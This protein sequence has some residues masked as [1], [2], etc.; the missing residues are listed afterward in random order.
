[1]YWVV[2]NGLLPMTPAGHGVRTVMERDYD[3]TALV[4]TID[5]TDSLW[6]VKRAGKA[7]W[8][9][10][11]MA[12]SNAWYR[13]IHRDFDEEKKRVGGDFTKSLPIRFLEGKH[14]P[15]YYF[16]DQIVQIR[17]RKDF[18][19]KLKTE[20]FSERV[21]FVHRPSFVPG[22]GKIVGLRERANSAIID[23]VADSRSF[24]VMSVTP[25][26]YWRVTI[27]GREVRPAVTNIGYQGVEIPA[28]THRVTM[29]YSND[30]IDIGGPISGG[31][32]ALLILMAI[33]ARRRAPVP[34]VA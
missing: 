1:V 31:T 13:G 19:D 28:G 32:A 20:T 2:R 14:Y 24:L 25:H 18:V 29:V 27:D 7:D 34:Q 33:F 6:D 10:P 5:F 22:A 4:P 21:A 11:F 16:S 12:M 30:M 9:Q 3:K 17:D 8:W 26:K 15:R 23:V